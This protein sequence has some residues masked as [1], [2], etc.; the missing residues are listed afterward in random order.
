VCP[1]QSIH[2]VIDEARSGDHIFV[3]AGTY[4]EQL[5]IKTDGISLIGVGAILTPPATPISN[6]CSGLAGPETEAGICV[7]RAVPFLY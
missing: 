4:T 3:P 6:T 2:S 5:T 1:G 7:T